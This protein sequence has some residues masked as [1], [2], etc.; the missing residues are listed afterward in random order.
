MKAKITVLWIA[1]LFTACATTGTLQKAPSEAGIAKK[2]PFK[3]AVITDVTQNALHN[4]GFTLIEYGKQKNGALVI[5]AEKSASAFSW[6][7]I[8]RIRIEEMSDSTVVR[9]LTKRRLATNVTAKGDWSTKIFA[10]IEKQL[11]TQ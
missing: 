7:E 8:V 10:D 3:A 1:L 5:I 6:G 9:I 11:K 2:Y 4:L